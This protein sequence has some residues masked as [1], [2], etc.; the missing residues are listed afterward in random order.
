[1]TLRRLLPPLPWLPL[2]ACGCSAYRVT[3][4]DAPAVAPFQEPVADRAEVCVLRAG[5]PA[6]LYTIAVY[7][8]GKLVGATHDGTYFCYLAEPGEHLIVSDATFGTR[9]A[10]LTAMVGRRYFLEQTWL[11]PAVRGHV[12]SWVDAPTAREEIEGEQYA[13]LSEVPAAEALPDARPFAPA[14]H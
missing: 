9:S 6:P 7:D 3:T 10:P 8:N 2:L 4:S 1:M 11:L 5:V 13:V 12:L 14:R